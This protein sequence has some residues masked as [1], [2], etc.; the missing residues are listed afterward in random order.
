MEREGGSGLDFLPVPCRLK[1]LCKLLYLPGNFL[2]FTYLV[3]FY[4]I[5][6]IL[7]SLCS[8]D[9]IKLQM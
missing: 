6:L 8:E 1:T 7:S 3:S 2:W 5:G 4:G 9:Q